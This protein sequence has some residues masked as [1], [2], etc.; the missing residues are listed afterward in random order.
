M[1]YYPEYNIK[2]IRLFA[3]D[4]KVEFYKKLGFIEN[5]T[6]FFEDELFMDMVTTVNR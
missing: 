2:L 3:E 4:N 6:V 1:F 5:G